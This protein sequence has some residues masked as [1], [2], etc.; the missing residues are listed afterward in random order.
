[1]KT[2][3]TEELKKIATVHGM[4]LYQVVFRLYQLRCQA[5]KVQN[6]REATCTA[7]M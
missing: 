5:E 6:D 4:T 7:A 3:T 2:F 1:M